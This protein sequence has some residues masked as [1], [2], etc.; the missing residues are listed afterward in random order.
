L[1]SRAANTVL[2]LGG[3]GM[4]GVQAA[5]EVA[6]EINPRTIVI[7]SLREDE[8][9]EAI[10]FLKEEISGPRLVGEWG[11]IFVPDALRL[12]ARD[13]LFSNSGNYDLLFD[14]VFRRE[15]NYRESALFKLV[16]KYQPEI[17]VDCI[18][19]AT[20]ISY[21]N[22]FD[23]AIKTKEML[24]ALAKHDGAVPREEL[25][26]FLASVRQ[27]LIAQGIPQIARHI[28][29]LHQTLEDSA[30][31]IYVKV[32]TTGTGGMGLNIP[33]THSEDK[34]SLPL[35]AKSAIGFAHTG[36]LFLLARTPASEDTHSRIIKEVKPGAMIGFRRLE[37]K[38]VRVRGE[39]GQAYLFAPREEPVGG[40]LELQQDVAGYEKF[41]ARD[42]PLE[43]IGADTGENG[44]FSVGEFL[45]ITYPRQMEYVTPEEVARTAILEILGASTGRDVLAAIDGAITEPSYRAGVMREHAVREMARLESEKRGEVPSI[46]LG[47]L[48]PPK[49]SKLL[50]EAHLI[51]EAAGTNDISAIRAIAPAELRRRVE[52]FLDDNPIVASTIVRIGTPILRE[53]NG[54]LTLTRG[55]RIT[56]PPITAGH[57]VVDLTPE[58]VERY[59]KAGWVDLRLENFEAWQRRLARI[60]QRDVERYGSAALDVRGYPGAEFVPG[61]IVGWIFTNE[62]DEQGMIGRRLL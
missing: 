54:K 1:A 51:R 59:A 23:V 47:H 2:I 11:N 48:G 7:A 44:F 57:K 35:L 58:N 16:E 19:T 33:Y 24:D 3:A 39:E 21:Q 25:E 17:I 49:L 20:G 32:G 42:V 5:R 27:L 62:E 60:K 22:E 40:R 29:V 38:H 46:A 56:I 31:Q 13:E 36:L 30:V 45:A 4:V 61:D 55:P 43:I 53:R 52:D 18:N 15:S 14:A 34:P 37:K 8:V 10:T 28:L 41:E 9:S 6:R 12:T 26:P 50:A